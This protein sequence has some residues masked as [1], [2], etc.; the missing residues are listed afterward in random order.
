M[1]ADFREHSL[2][3]RQIRT[4]RAP[5]LSTNSKDGRQF[6]IVF[7]YTK[8]RQKSEELI[9]TAFNFCSTQVIWR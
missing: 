6:G 1:S 2:I 7:A 8:K 5:L 3:E 4:P 9:A